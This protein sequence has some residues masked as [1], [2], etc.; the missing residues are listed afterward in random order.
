MLQHCLP[1][2]SWVNKVTAVSTGYMNCAKASQKTDVEP[3]K[4]PN[5]APTLDL[6][7]PVTGLVDF[8][9]PVWLN[10]VFQ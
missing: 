7:K 8:P 3:F 4:W 10:N 2:P 5:E 6:D 1:T 9:F